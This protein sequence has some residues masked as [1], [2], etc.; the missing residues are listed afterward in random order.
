MYEI[1]Y[2]PYICYTIL[3]SGP[4][5]LKTLS[6]HHLHNNV[7]AI[8]T[9]LGDTEY[10]L[11][12]CRNMPDNLHLARPPSSRDLNAVLSLYQFFDLVPKL[13][14]PAHTSNIMASLMEPPSP[15]SSSR[16]L[17]PPVPTQE[18]Q[19]PIKTFQLRR[20]I[21]GGRTDVLIQTFDDR[22]LVIVTQNEKVGILVSPSSTHHLVY[23]VMGRH[24]H[25]A[26][27]VK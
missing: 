20:M 24:A 19:S 12:S 2:R 9:W 14:K 4:L 3:S 17:T 10:R 25:G 22:I 1:S 8:Y 13:S 7:L 6:E 5:L 26:E 21:P 15:P 11:S 16:P 18:A 27:L 23:T